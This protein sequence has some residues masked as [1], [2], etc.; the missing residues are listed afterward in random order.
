M[1]A[2]LRT[3]QGVEVDVRDILD[4]D[5]EVGTLT[6][7][8]RPVEMCASLRQQRCWNTSFAGKAA[9]TTKEKQGYWRG[10]IFYRPYLAHRVAWAIYYG[11]WPK[12]EIDHI[13]GIRSNNRITNLRSVTRQENMRNSAIHR[14]NTSGVCGVRKHRPSGKW[15]AQIGVGGRDVS[16]GYFTNIEDAAAARKS[17]EQHYGYHQNHGRA[18]ID[19]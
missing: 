3:P 9:F 14:D 5:P 12:G 10:T 6:W 19:G 11:E 7:L 18:A 13:D 8:S 1:K 16:L 2:T 4:Y 17:A 15:H